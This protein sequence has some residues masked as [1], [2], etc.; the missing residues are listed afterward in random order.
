M[1]D[2]SH[3]GQRHKGC[4][5]CDQEKRAGNAQERRPARDRREIERARGEVTAAE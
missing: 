2:K 3:K 5:L 4:P 1:K